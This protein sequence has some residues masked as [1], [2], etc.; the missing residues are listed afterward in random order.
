MSLEVER[1][2][3]TEIRVGDKISAPGY[4][5]FAGGF[6]EV[7]GIEPTQYGGVEPDSVAA[8]TEMPYERGEG[9]AK[10]IPLT[11]DVELDG[12]HFVS[13]SAGKDNVL[14]LRAMGQYVDRV[15]A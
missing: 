14:R 15:M 3:T 9:A 1:I 13:P 2:A 5:T 12:P 10:E 4:D 11:L 6:R 8:R 7:T